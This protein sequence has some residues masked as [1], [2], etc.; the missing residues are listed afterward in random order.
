MTDIE[1]WSEYVVKGYREHK[2]PTSMSIFIRGL[3]PTL[4]RSIDNTMGI[5]TQRLNRSP[6]E[7]NPFLGIF[8]PL[9]LG[10]VVQI[11]LGLF[12]LLLTYDSICGE[13]EA[14]TLR[15]YASFPVPRHR[16][17]LGKL[18]GALIPTWIGFGLPL[19][20]GIAVVLLLPDVQFTR[21]EL[22]R[23]GLILVAFGLYLTVLTCVGLLA[24][25]LTHRAPT[26]SCSCWGSG[27]PPWWWC[28]VSA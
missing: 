4:G 17:L 13:K 25:C 12:V 23:L 3:E 21:P 26:S 14:G 27:C 1:W 7:V 28:R 9:D 10:L 5:I 20:L 8:P 24:S 15:L 16:L 18:L 6:V 22:N 2:P 11:V 19:L